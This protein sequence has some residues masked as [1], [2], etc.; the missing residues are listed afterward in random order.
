MAQS[1][2]ANL[3][4]D[5]YFNDDGIEIFVGNDGKWHCNRFVTST[6]R[7]WSSPDKMCDDKDHYQCYVC[8]AFQKEHEPN[9]PTQV[10]RPSSRYYRGEPSG[11]SSVVYPDSYTINTVTK[12]DRYNRQTVRK[13]KIVLMDDGLW[14]CNQKNF[15]RDGTSKR[16]NC[17]YNGDQ[18][19][20]CYRYQRTNGPS[21]PRPNPTED[22]KKVPRALY[23]NAE[24]GDTFLITYTF[25]A[26]RGEQN[27]TQNEYG[28][29]YYY[30]L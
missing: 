2:V 18:C 3:F 27:L 25:L 14:H 5:T 29:L 30:S 19:I 23:E 17:I 21:I 15:F 13:D 16:I 20:D 11:T 12:T 22:K 6:T 28:E 8:E 4:L 1:N 9:K 7:T 24:E 26:S 10:P